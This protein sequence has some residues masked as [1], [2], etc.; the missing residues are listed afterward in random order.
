MTI[1]KNLDNPAKLY[2]D[3]SKALFAKSD[4]S[5]LKE[6]VAKHALVEEWTTEKESALQECVKE[7]LKEDS[8]MI[9]VVHTDL[10]KTKK[11]IDSFGKDYSYEVGSDDSIDIDAPGSMEFDEL[12]KELR[13]KKIRFKVLKESLKTLENINNVAERISEG[14]VQVKKRFKDAVVAELSKKE[15]CDKDKKEETTE[16]KEYEITFSPSQKEKLFEF[17]KDLKIT[18]SNNPFKVVVEASEEVIATL[19]EG[20]VDVKQLN[21]EQYEL[22]L[23]FDS[24]EELES[25]MET[26]N[27]AI[28]GDDL[29]DIGL[30]EEII[31][32]HAGPDGYEISVLGSFEEIEEVLS[33][34]DI[35]IDGISDDN[36]IELEESE[37]L[38][39]R[40]I[41]KWVVRAGKKIKKKFTDKAT[42]KIVGGKEK[43]MSSK[44]RIK[45]KR[46]AKKSAKK[47]RGKLSRMLRKRKISL[48][49]RGSLNR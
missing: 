49:K 6:S 40:L 15:D 13:S 30:E 44:E 35:Q 48:R 22:V 23:S 1:L 37:I 16:L 36:E 26:L 11:I 3:V 31:Q 38:V 14:S 25:A 27:I 24:D 41:K 7:A 18:K 43:F 12:K 21:D 42:K 29:D 17:I 9:R 4:I 32:V 20:V 39:E 19:K 45:R 47:R 10:A 33:D 46:S 5:S 8:F 34:L 2:E 28:D